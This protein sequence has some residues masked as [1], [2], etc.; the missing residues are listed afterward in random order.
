MQTKALQKSTSV[1]C[2][3]LVSATESLKAPMH[4]CIRIGMMWDDALLIYNC[5][6]RTYDGIKSGTIKMNK[7]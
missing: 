3:F 2:F 7:Y 1:F 6:N 4:G 5:S